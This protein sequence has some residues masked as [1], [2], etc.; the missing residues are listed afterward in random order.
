MGNE[1]S[2]DTR[3]GAL[4]GAAAAVGAGC[5]LL[6]AL[7]APP[8]MMLVNG[9]ALLVG[10]AGVAAIWTSCRGGA[11]E[12]AGDVALLVASALLP[13]TALAGPEASGVA[14][15]LV[16]GGLTLQPAMI[17][18]PVI[19][20]GLVL[21]PSPMRT[22]AALVAALGL[23]M[24]PDPGGAA[25]LLFGLVAL[26]LVKEHRRA[27]DL[28]GVF[29]AAIGVAVAQARTVAL[30]PVPFVEQVIPDAL[31][32]GALTAILAL[33]ATLLLFAPAIARPLRAAN[34]AFLGV[35]LAAVAMALL[36]PYPTP[37]I[38]FGGSSV[39]GF[40]LS[41]GLLSLGVGTLRRG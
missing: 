10:L 21:R 14:R 17:V 38:G 35:W 25:M 9:A 13:L 28:A 34:L 32:A 40:V 30:P 39:L 6:A 33:A 7:G 27:S 23:A 19:V 20:L 26:M 11:T 24:Q 15:W 8:R 36:G 41:A 2:V 1:R 12:R 31:R 29:G 5:A 3:W 4:A 18:V 37:V 22:A 16:V